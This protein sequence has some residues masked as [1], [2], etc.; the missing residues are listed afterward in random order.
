MASNSSQDEEGVTPVFTEDMVHTPEVQ[1]ER[2]EDKSLPT[3]DAT[4]EPST[5]KRSGDE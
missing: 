5:T 4:K 2:R 3:E 1:D